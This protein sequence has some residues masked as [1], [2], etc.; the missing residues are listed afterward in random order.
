MP[1]VVDLIFA[2]LVGVLVFTPLSVRLLG[3]AGIGWHIRT[4]QQILQTHAIPRV[5]PFSSTMGG[6]AWYAWEWLYDLVA[7]QLEAVLGLNGV[8]WFA[9][10]AIAAVFA[11][12]FCW[13]M[14]RGTNL[15]VA[16][17][18]TLLAVSA[19]T[20]HFLARP[21]VLTWLFV[22]VWFCILDS[23]EQACFPN[24]SPARAGK[25]WLL[26]LLMLVWVNLHGGFLFGFVLLGIYW[27][28]A[29]W[30]WARTREERLEDAFER[31]AAGKRSKQLL[32]AGLLSAAASFANPY[33]WKL[34]AHI[35]SYLSNRFL[36][37]HI[38][39]FQSP[40]FHGM[41]Q[42]CFLVLLLIA[43]A[44]LA[45][46]GRELRASH[47]LIALFAICMGLY[48]SRNIPVSSVLLTIIVAPLIGIPALDFQFLKRMTALESTLRGRAWC[49][50]V[51]VV[52]FFIALNGG[53][54][55]ST[56]FIDGHFDPRRMPVAAVDYLEKHEV[57]G[58]V[59]SPDSWGGYLIYRLYPQTKV[60]ADDRH[61][62]YGEDFF[63]SYLKLMHGEP[64]WQ[65]FLR[66]HPAECALLPKSSP[67]ATLLP[68]T[69]W[70][71]IYHDDT[72]IL[73]IRGVALRTSTKE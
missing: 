40:N 48:S 7:G 11:A 63:K 3:D 9:A 36:M 54:V 57:P 60:V 46:R 16:L 30:A 72:A 19:S 39:E 26:P 14:K 68:Q 49:I 73:L 67:L 34:H 58:P 22:L 25:L 2:A 69:G 15:L 51:T 10:I 47:I 24:R 4:G 64:G 70:I 18:F 44:A 32:Y 21:H 28:A 56:Q 20:I 61:D 42:K 65:D 1:S 31:I 45:L 8:V 66:D 5:D 23:S 33:G 37:D 29:L 59:F 52:T 12:M 50:V 43:V 35:Y 62:L 38:E 17:V 6:K 55:G 71:A 53:R 41:A 13:L 27:L